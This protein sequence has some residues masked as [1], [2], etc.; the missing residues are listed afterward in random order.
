MTKEVLQLNHSSDL[1]NIQRNRTKGCKGETPTNIQRQK[2]GN[3]IR[4]VVSYYKSQGG[5]D[6]IFHILKENY[7]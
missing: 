3:N 5:T 4:A 7:Y 2:Q 1:K 6:D